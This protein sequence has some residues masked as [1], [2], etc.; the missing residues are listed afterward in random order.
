MAPYDVCETV[1][2]LDGRVAKELSRQELNAQLCIV[3]DAI[4]DVIAD[5]NDLSQRQ[6][7]LEKALKG[8][9]CG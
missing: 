1:E 4:R 5:L 7:C 2:F 6:L 9:L 8:E 3:R